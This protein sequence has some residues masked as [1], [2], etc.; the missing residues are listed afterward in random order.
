ML[1]LKRLEDV[2]LEVESLVGATNVASASGLKCSQSPIKLT[3]E[4]FWTVYPKFL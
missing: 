3:F 2:G 1:Y 4:S